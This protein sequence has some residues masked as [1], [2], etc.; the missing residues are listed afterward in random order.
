[1]V[2]DRTYGGAGALAVSAQNRSDTGVFLVLSLAAG[3]IIAVF[4]S[5][6]FARHAKLI[7]LS[8]LPVGAFEISGRSSKVLMTSQIPRLLRLTKEQE[9]L[10]SRDKDEFIRFLKSLTSHRTEVR[11]DKDGYRGRNPV[12]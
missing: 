5:Q 9:H 12:D 6:W 2:P 3:L 1:M 4:T 7:E 8:E 10:F 11:C